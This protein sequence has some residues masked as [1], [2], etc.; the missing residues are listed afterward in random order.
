MATVRKPTHKRNKTTL[1]V[2]DDVI[3]TIFSHLPVKKLVG[4]SILSK[5]FRYSW[6]FC[7]DI[8]FDSDF[9][10]NLSRNEFKN[11]VN[12]FFQNYLNSTADRFSLYFDAIEE[13]NL[14]GYWIQQAVRLG[15]KE[16]ELDFTPSQRRFMLS[17]DLVNVDTIKIMKLVNCE[18]QLP[19]NPINCLSNL[20]D[21]TFQNVRARP[22]AIKTVFGNCL[23]LRILRLINCNFIFDLKIS[24]QNLKRFEILVVRDCS[25]VDSVFINAPHLSSL[26]Y[27]GKICEFNFEND[28]S[29]I[30]D[31]ILNIAHPRGFQILPH[32]KDM[33]FSLALVRTL[34]VSSIFLEGLC[35]KFDGTEYKELEFYL[36]KLKEFHLVVAP[37]SHLNPC[38]IVIFLKYCPC[39][40]R[41]FIDLGHNA[42]MNSLYWDFHGRKYLSGCDTVF[43]FLKYMKIKGF[44][45]RE[46]PVMMA[47]FFLKNAM[48]L[49]CLVLVKARNFDFPGTFTPYYLRWGISSNA[50]I[51]VYEYNRD[52]SIV[53]PEHLKG[54]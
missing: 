20:I 44:T 47:R 35:P 33:V 31:V 53:I 32:I 29:Q 39:V 48:N 37:E 21:L 14:V 10:R 22:L 3:E 41:V 11:I 15:I 1:H 54:F 7:R 52:I 50:N 40:E 12:N 49:H 19:F 25:E 8:S 38:D 13:T 24:A 27:H 34:T 26:H 18:L 28:F 30:K 43:P 36:W 23:A 46:L 5:R 45:A 51:E 4:L 9:A 17:Y 2:S 42:F 16:I 6:K